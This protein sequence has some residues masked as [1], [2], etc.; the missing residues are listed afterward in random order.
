MNYFTN[1][2]LFGHFSY[3]F[4]IKKK[5]RNPV[6]SHLEL[7]RGNR[8]ELLLTRQLASKLEV[9]TIINKGKMSIA[10]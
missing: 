9:T 4:E 8:S 5:R 6:K 1:V 10:I 3:C 2:F 7:L